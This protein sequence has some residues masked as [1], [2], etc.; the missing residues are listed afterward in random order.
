MYTLKLSAFIP[1]LALFCAGGAAAQMPKGCAGTGSDLKELLETEYAFE[2]KAQ[3]SV[4][5]AFLA[6]L[7][8]DSLVLQPKPTP[9]RPFYEATKPSSDNLQWYPAIAAVALGGDL[10]FSTGPWIYTTADGT[11]IYGDFITV[12]KRDPSCQWRAQFDGG[13][14]HPMPQQTAPKL[15]P[16]AVGT[17]TAADLG[18]LPKKPVALDEARRDF[19]RTA[20]QDGLAAGLRT[21]ARDGDFRFYVEGQAPQGAGPANQYLAGHVVGSWS[22]DAQGRSADSTL[23]YSV[24]RFTNA[25]KGGQNAY[26][27]IWQYDPK[28][29]NWGLRIFLM[30]PI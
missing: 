10:G 9:G 4:R 27:Q 13:I 7:A 2:S 22:E 30:T 16:A 17:A 26:L 25:K 23:A 29:A 19:E 18:L 28:V 15:L 21:Y 14:S 6:Y 11:H 3:E 24:G 8:E 12:W 20:Q 1:I 5:N